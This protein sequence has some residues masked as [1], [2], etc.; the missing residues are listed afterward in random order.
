MIVL[1]ANEFGSA[2]TAALLSTAHEVLG[3]GVSIRVE[4]FD[5][6]P[7]NER[8]AVPSPA[9]APGA[10]TQ[11]ASELPPGQEPP[12]TATYAWLGWDE[13]NPNLAHLKCF[14]PESHRWIVRDVAFAPQDPANESGRTLGFVIA[15]MYLGS[16][17]PVAIPLQPVPQKTKNDRAPQPHEKRLLAQAAAS[18]ALP[19]DV[20]SMGG[21]LSLQ[22]ALTHSIALGIAAE[23]RFGT[24]PEAQANVRFIGLGALLDL[25]LWPRRGAFWFGPQL[26]AGAEQVHFSHFSGDD[27]K[28]VGQSAWVPR[29][30]VLLNFN[31][32]LSETSLVFLGIGTNYRFGETDTYV[33]T[34]RRAHI[35][36]WVGV[37]RLG[38][39]TRF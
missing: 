13:A 26:L 14:I 35:P 30:D 8:P 27:P 3:P 21:L 9:S 32:Q 12:G 39:G 17:S 34:I 5:P 18:L 2:R 22:A 16:E 7:S 36:A 33:R 4:A 23:V 10:P 11:S 38:I 29:S 25:R 37:A 28:P 1:A 15:S 19:G 6:Q 31:W 20:T 24:V